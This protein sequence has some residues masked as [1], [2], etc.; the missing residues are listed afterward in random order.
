MS[1]LVYYLLANWLPTL[2]KS[3]GQTNQSATLIALML[4]LGSTVGALGIGYL[5]DRFGGHVTLALSYALA[6]AFVLLLAF[7]IERPSLLVLTVFC[8]GMGTGGS[9]TGL[10]ALV[11]AFYP[12]ASRAT[13]VSWANAM[14]RIGSL[15]GSALAGYLLT[16]GLGLEGVF[17]AACVPPLIAALA[18]TA[19]GWTAPGGHAHAIHLLDARDAPTAHV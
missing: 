8:A 18:V 13:G 6:A 3:A 17:A 16:M 11:A 10:N 2:L 19:K 9:N 7:S 4:P 12:T 15:A 14:G 1:L 5:M